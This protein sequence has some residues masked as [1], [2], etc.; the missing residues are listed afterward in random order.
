MDWTEESIHHWLYCC[1]LYKSHRNQ[2]LINSTLLQWP[3]FCY[4]GTNDSINH[5]YGENWGNGVCKC[6]F[7]NRNLFDDDEKIEL[8]VGLVV[9]LLKCIR[10]DMPT[11]KFFN[12][13]CIGEGGC[14][15][16]GRF[17]R[18]FSLFFAFS[19]FLNSDRHF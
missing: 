18:R 7:C 3:E 5:L 9:L 16:G 11:V 6:R 17:F 8:L 19:P 12:I 1:F 4:L 10:A 13:G 15:V 2:F 14:W